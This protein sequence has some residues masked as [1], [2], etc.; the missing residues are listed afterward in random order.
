MTSEGGA[1]LVILCRIQVRDTIRAVRTT[2]PLVPV[3]EPTVGWLELFYDLIMVAAVVV[4]SI[5]IIRT[6]DLFNILWFLAGFALVWWAWLCTTLTMNV[7]RE[8]NSTAQ[9]LVVLQM[10]AII[11][12]A[13]LLA[14]PVKAHNSYSIPLFGVVMLLVAALNEWLRRTQA[15]KDQT[16]IIRRRNAFAASGLLWLASALLDEPAKV[17]VCVLATIVM[18]A[19]LLS[20]WFNK[21]ITL[22]WLD[23]KHIGERFALLTM[24]V[25]GE[26]FIKVAGAA[27]IKPVAATNTLCLGIEMLMIF[28]VWLSYFR[29][30]V[31]EGVPSGVVARRAWMFGHLLLQISLLGVAIGLGI[32]VKLDESRKV[33]DIDMIALTVPLAVVFVFLCILGLSS[34]SGEPRLVEVIRLSCAV[35]IGVVGW[36]TWRYDAVTVDRGMAGMAALMLAT[37]A[38]THRLIASDSPRRS[39]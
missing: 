9:W 26:S 32:F 23:P 12:M 15:T 29:D 2:P 35:G 20:G 36:M 11:Y 8:V 16:F 17:V 10:V 30:I 4:F 21:G 31:P 28:A 33:G 5:A 39:H 6:P 25:L 14:D 19:P 7:Q 34:A 18:I 37:A 38:V 3:E 22:E 27:A 24:L 13:V 1:D